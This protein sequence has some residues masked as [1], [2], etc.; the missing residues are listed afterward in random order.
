MLLQPQGGA[1]AQ[2]IAEVLEVLPEGLRTSV[3]SETHSADAIHCISPQRS[4][5]AHPGSG[6]PSTRFFV[7]TTTAS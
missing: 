1:L 6:M 5:T 4:A 7:T 2:S 3:S